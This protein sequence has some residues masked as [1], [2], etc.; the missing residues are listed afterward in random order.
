MASIDDYLLQELGIT[1]PPPSK[2]KTYFLTLSSQVSGGRFDPNFYQPI[3]SQT[4]EKIKSGFF[5]TYYL[6][7]LIT[8]S[9]ESWNGKDF[10]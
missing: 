3:F 7:D 5:N 4:I 9:T 6:R 8:F 1:L 2:K 10:L